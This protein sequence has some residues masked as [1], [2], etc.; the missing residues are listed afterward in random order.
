VEPKGMMASA[1]KGVKRRGECGIVSEEK[2]FIAAGDTDEEGWKFFKNDEEL[3]KSAHDRNMPITNFHK[4]LHHI[5]FQE[6]NIPNKTSA[7]R[8]SNNENSGFGNGVGR[9]NGDKLLLVV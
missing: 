4:P 1:L 6:F 5:P 3:E 7:T 8:N 2:K 9:R